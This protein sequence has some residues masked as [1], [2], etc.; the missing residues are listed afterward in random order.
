MSLNK[1]VNV[2]ICDEENIKAVHNFFIK[3]NVQ[4]STGTYDEFFKGKG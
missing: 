3:Y 1:N 2:C 4:I